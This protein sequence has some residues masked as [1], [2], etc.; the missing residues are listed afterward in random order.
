MIKIFLTL[1]FVFFA[2]F[3]VDAGYVRKIK[4]PN[5]FIPEAYQ[6]QKQERLPET[7][8]SY[9]SK[10]VPEYKR[11]YNEYFNDVR[12]FAK[13][14]IMPRNLKLERDLNA[15]QKG[16]VFEVEASSNIDESKEIKKFYDIAEDILGK[17]KL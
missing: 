1:F 12:V 17:L 10:Y 2:V 6:M 14:G 4:K 3:S 16:D 13:N 15:M 7:S 8:F 9:P 11:K 5:F